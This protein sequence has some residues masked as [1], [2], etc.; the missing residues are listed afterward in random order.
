MGIDNKPRVKIELDGDLYNT[1]MKVLDDWKSRELDTIFKISAGKLEEK[2]KIYAHIF[3]SGNDE[4]VKIF[5][6]E[7]EAALLLE[8][9]ILALYPYIDS[10]K[11]YFEDLKKRKKSK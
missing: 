3:K 2:I 4:A 5:F 1:L 8:M 9:L 11:N 10:E 6:F 7:N